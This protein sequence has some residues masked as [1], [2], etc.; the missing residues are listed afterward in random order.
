MPA[1]R[2]SSVGVRWIAMYLRPPRRFA[3][4]LPEG[5]GCAGRRKQLSAICGLRSGSEPPRIRCSTPNRSP[6]ELPEP[7]H[8]ERLGGVVAAGDEVRAALAR[9]RHDV[10]G[11][12][13][14]EERVEP[15][16]DRL[17]EARRRGAGHDADA[18]HGLGPV[19]Q[20]NGSWPK[21]SSA[22]A[23]GAPSN[24][25]ALRRAPH[26]PDRLPAVLAERLGRARA[27]APRRS[28]RCCPPRDGRRAAGGRRRATMSASNR[29]RR[30]CFIAGVIE[31]GWKSQ[32]SPWWATHQLGAERG[33]AARTARDGLTRP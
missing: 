30:R 20:T 24:G 29:T 5:I 10:L 9:V 16:R 3:E 15:L 22:P 8:A 32:N 27:R 26:E 23:R 17:A 1:S 7:P 2:P 18:V 25:D 11:G 14:G 28:A 13:A 31:R 6:S 4:R 21:A 19:S 12:L 33:S